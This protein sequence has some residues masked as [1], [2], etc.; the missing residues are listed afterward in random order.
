MKRLLLGMLLGLWWHPFQDSKPTLSARE[1]VAIVAD[2]DVKH[3]DQQP[4][5]MP[6][7]GV[8]NFESNPPAVWIFN[9][10]DTASK[11]STVIHELRHIH[12]HQLGLEPDEELIRE[13]EA[14]IY[15][16]LFGGQP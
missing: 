12:Y 8:T 16:D 3:V 7:F 2:Y 15:L 14:Q 9:T 11:R 1:C 4:F 13:E 10:G 5:Y 6:A